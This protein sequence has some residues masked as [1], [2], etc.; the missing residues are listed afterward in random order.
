MNFFIRSVNYLTLLDR[1]LNDAAEREWMAVHPGNVG[2]Y[3]LPVDRSE[4]FPVGRP[5]L[6]RLDLRL[7]FLIKGS[8]WQSDRR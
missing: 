1:F 3:E 7:P 2:C 5:R 8:M 6:R 4:Q